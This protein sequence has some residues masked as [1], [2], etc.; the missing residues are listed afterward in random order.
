M[1]ERL[2]KVLM[3]KYNEALRHG[4]LTLDLKKELILILLVIFGLITHYA[5]VT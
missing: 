3:Y 1:S 2:H 4:Y 5:S